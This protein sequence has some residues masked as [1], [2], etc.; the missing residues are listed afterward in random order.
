M[1]FYFMGS[2][3]RVPL[4]LVHRPLQPLLLD[5]PDA[6]TATHLEGRIGFDRSELEVVPVC[7]D[8]REQRLLHLGHEERVLT[9]AAVAEM[10]EWKR[11]L[12]LLN[13]QV[14]NTYVL[15]CLCALH[16]ACKA[17]ARLSEKA[18]PSNLF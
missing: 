7:L 17:P 2:L 9:G 8:V 1:F 4:V 12:K 16:P 6:G 18:P 15:V 14:F 13:K 5:C 10:K 3:Q 11:I